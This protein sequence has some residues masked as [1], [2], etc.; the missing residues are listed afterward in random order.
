MFELSER[1]KK[2]IPIVI[3]CI[4]LFFI[5]KPSICFKPNN[6]PRE[7]GVGLDSDGYKKTFFSMN[8]MIIVIV[9]LVYFLNK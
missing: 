9:L 3:F 5:V 8:I 7:Y 1:F 6:Q 2:N 4:L